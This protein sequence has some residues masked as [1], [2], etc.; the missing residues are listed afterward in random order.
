MFPP[1]ALFG[2]PGAAKD[3]WAAHQTSSTCAFEVSTEL[4]PLADAAL[5]VGGKGLLDVLHADPPRT[6]P[7]LP[8]QPIDENLQNKTPFVQRNHEQTCKDSTDDFSSDDAQHSFWWLLRTSYL[9]FFAS[10][11]FTQ[12]S[13]PRHVSASGSA[14]FENEAWKNY[15]SW[16]FVLSH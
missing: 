7:A 1:P 12:R 8:E 4:Q 15:L 5:G 14:V 16:K 13:F 2:A 9:K 6:V 10:H 11:K 3:G